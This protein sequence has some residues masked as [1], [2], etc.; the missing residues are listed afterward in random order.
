M[1]GK[2]IEFGPPAPRQ[3]RPAQQSAFVPQA[4]P[5]QPQVPPLQ[6]PLQ[7][8]PGRLQGEPVAWQHDAGPNCDRHSP[9]AQQTEEPAQDCPAETQPQLPLTQTPEQQSVPEP[10]A[11]ALGAQQ[12]PWRQSRPEQ[13]SAAL[14]QPAWEAP[15]PQRPLEPHEPLQQPASPQA[16]P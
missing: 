14:L 13:Q 7:Q 15:Q 4:P 5:P 8:S 2:H 10:Q 1:H 11:A 9:P 6:T 16:S 12:P 3:V